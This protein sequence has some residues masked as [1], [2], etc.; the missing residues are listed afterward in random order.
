MKFVDPQ[1]ALDLDVG[2]VPCDAEAYAAVLR[3]RDLVDVSKVRLSEGGLGSGL[4]ASGWTPPV[5]T[6]TIRPRPTPAGPRPAPTNNL[7]TR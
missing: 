4:V 5:A 3:E 7:G 2:P 1:D 6:G